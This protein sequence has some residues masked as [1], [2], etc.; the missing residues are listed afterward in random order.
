M[1]AGRVPANY[2]ITRERHGWAGMIV[3]VIAPELIARVNA[4]V[5]NSQ[6]YWKGHA[7]VPRDAR[8]LELS[9]C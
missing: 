8:R 3:I 4:G 7:L 9:V 2:T 1:Q 6:T 5:S